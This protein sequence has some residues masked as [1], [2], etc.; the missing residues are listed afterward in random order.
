[1]P[2]RPG[3][4]PP[5]PPCSECGGPFHEPGSIVR[6]HR[7]DCPRTNPIKTL[8]AV[9]DAA[10]RR[11]EV[12]P[13][14]GDVRCDPTPCGICGC[15]IGEGLMLLHMD[16]CHP[17]EPPPLPSR[18][19]GRYGPDPLDHTE[20]LEALR[21]NTQDAPP[22]VKELRDAGVIVAGVGKQPPNP[23]PPATT[24]TAIP[25]PPGTSVCP[26]Q[27]DGDDAGRD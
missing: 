1:M 7:P 10:R 4:Y 13:A 9:A 26:E 23:P 8:P 17:A 12:G 21:R 24:V 5:P 27:I 25:P 20:T 19:A 18:R 11:K 15:V 14:G 6:W 3:P 22:P 2:E 16:A